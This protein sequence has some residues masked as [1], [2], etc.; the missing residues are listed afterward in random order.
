VLWGQAQLLVVLKKYAPTFFTI[1]LPNG[2]WLVGYTSINS[3]W[4][5]KADGV[6]EKRRE[7]PNPVKLA[8]AKTNTI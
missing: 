4:Q 5:G 6:M 8:P 3:S 2:N 1:T 7:H